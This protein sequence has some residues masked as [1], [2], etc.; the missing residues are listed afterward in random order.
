VGVLL[1]LRSLLP[2]HV[3]RDIIDPSPLLLFPN[4]FGSCLC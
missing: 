4:L 2:L 3:R 1:S